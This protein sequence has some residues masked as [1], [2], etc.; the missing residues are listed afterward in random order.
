[1]SS[2]L[3]NDICIEFPNSSLVHCK[4]FFF[5]MSEKFWNVIETSMQ[6]KI[7]YFIKNAVK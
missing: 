6:Y 3:F 5:S 4:Q 7:P 1:M 2:R